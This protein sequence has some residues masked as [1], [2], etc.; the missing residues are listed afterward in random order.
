LK[1]FE[2]KKKEEKIVSS[3]EV[4]DIGLQVEKGKGGAGTPMIAPH[5]PRFLRKRRKG[6]YLETEK[7]GKRRDEF[8]FVI[9]PLD[10][11]GDFF[12]PLA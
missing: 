7:E 3:R 10:Q 12:R 2:R 9:P 6:L 1:T 4:T 11:V 8:A 5:G